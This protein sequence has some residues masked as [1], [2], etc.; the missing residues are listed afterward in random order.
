METYVT[1]RIKE[2][3]SLDIITFILS[4]V[5]LIPKEN[6]DYLQVFRIQKIQDTILIEHKQEVPE[7]TWYYYLTEQL[8]IKERLKLF[9]IEE[10][11]IRTL[12]FAE[13]Y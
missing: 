6:R 13:E 5:E 3:L 8:V 1:K 9:L 10:G 12:M 11:N 7:C 4:R 2:E